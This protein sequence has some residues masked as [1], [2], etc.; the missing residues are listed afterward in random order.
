MKRF[1]ALLFAAPLALSLAAQGPVKWEHDYQSALKRAK[2]EKKVIF[3]DLWAEWCG[4]CQ[5]LQKNVFPS[6][7]GQAALAKVVPFSSLVQKKD[8]TPLPEGTKLSETFQ[9]NA[10]PTLVILDQNGKEVRRNVGAFRS[11]A[12]FAAWL[13]T[14]TR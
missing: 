3:M 12:E 6:A 11:G 2:A 10:F 14:A 8:G 13:D 1:A 7:E 5:Y 4:P 9:L